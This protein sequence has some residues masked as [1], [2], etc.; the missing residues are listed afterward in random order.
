MR[1]GEKGQVTI[2]VEFRRALG[3]HA[4]DEVEFEWRE[5]EL[6]LRRGAGRGER[7]VRRLRGTSR[8][9]MTTDEL[10]ALTRS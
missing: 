1:V 7:I 10:L 9:G 3:L 6:V 2:P 5:S 4:G 8:S